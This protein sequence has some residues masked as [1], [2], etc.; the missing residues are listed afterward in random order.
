LNVLSHF[1]LFQ[2]PFKSLVTQ[3]AYTWM[4]HCVS[5]LC[6]SFVILI[7]NLYY[8][9]PGRPKVISSYQGFF[10]LQFVWF[11]PFFSVVSYGLV[12]LSFSFFVFPITFLFLFNY[13]NIF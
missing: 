4:H 1:D 8:V 10:L 9:S 5:H 2:F 3:N 13:Y 11:I 7:Y 12:S 6:H